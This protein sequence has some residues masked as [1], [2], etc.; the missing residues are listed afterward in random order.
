MTAAKS[1]PGLEERIHEWR[2]TRLRAF[3]GGPPGGDPLVLIHGLGGAA[4]NWAFLAPELARTRRVLAVDLPGHGGSEPLPA[5]P[6]LAPYADHVAAV[7]EAEGLLPADVAG[8][9]LGG[10]VALR[11]A[12]R[13]P[14][15]VKRL[16]LA[17]AAGISSSTRAAERVLALVGWIQPGR[18]ISPYWRLVAKSESLK[19]AVF[20]HWFASDPTGLDERAV[21]AILSEVNLHT[22]TDSAWRALTRDDPRAELELV[23]APCLVLWGADDNQL[24]LADAFDYAR[25]LRA[26]LRVIA[27][28]G[29]LLIVE[30]PEACL[31]AIEDFLAAGERA[32]PPQ[33]AHRGAQI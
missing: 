33:P 20:A 13:R 18:R 19:R 32:V 22:D 17:A 8:H 30:R 6:S 5:A 25:R 7:A 14:E 4:V 31:E 24:P 3:V 26:P 1:L 15:A 16:V 29:H 10:L 2:G 21:E 28:C 12:L 11:L 9:S 23:R 27:D